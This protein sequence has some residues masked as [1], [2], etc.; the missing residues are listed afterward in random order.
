MKRIFLL[1]IFVFISNILFSQESEKSAFDTLKKSGVEIRYNKARKTYQINDIGNIEDNKLINLEPIIQKI[2]TFG[3]G[4]RKS[5]MILNYIKKMSNVRV[6]FLEDGSFHDDDYEFINNMQ[7]LKI[8]SLKNNKITGDCFKKFQDL[9]QIETI[10][11][12][13]NNIIENN[14]NYLNNLRRLRVINLN[15]TPITDKAL[16]IIANYK[17]K[18]LAAVFV[19]GTKVTKT[20]AQRF[21]KLRGVEACVNANECNAQ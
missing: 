3:T 10:D 4:K 14:L 18:D 8:L 19:I 9:K 2:E 6:L 20:A 17:S 7:S 13:G 21:Y 1:T 16:E 15:N 11:L 12:T 5:K